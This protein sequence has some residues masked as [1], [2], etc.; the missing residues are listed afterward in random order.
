MRKPVTKANRAIG[1]RLRELRISRGMTLLQLGNAAGLRYQLVQTYEKGVN[2]APLK[3]LKRLAEI[4][5]VPVAYFFEPDERAL[6]AE[7]PSR[8]LMHLMRMLQSVEKHHPQ[9]FA[10][11]CKTAGAMARIKK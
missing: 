4:L 5:D 2:S 11:I 3:K 9:V 7:P 6:Q 10:G 1:R 8:R